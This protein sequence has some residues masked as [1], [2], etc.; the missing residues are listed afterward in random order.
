[1]NRIDRPEEEPGA[2]NR[3][4]SGARLVRRTASQGNELERFTWAVPAE[5]GCGKV[6]KSQNTHL[7]NRY[8]GHPAR[9]R[10]TKLEIRNSETRNASWNDGKECPTLSKTETERVG[11]PRENK[12]NIGLPR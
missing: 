12:I 10:K 2:L 7:R 4:G 8:V 1:M 6:W 5:Y 11:H 3:A 9:P